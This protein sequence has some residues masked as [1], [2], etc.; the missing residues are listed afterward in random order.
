MG[1]AISV[2]THRGIWDVH[3]SQCSWLSLTESVMI[4][5][6]VVPQFK[7]FSEDTPLHDL[8]VS[9]VKILW[10]H[11]GQGWKLRLSSLSS[12]ASNKSLCLRKSALHRSNRNWSIPLPSHDVGI[13]VNSG[14]L[15]VMTSRFWD[16]VSWE[17][18]AFHK[19]SYPII[20]RYK[21]LEHFPKALGDFSEIERFVYN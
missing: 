4:G 8:F 2:L 12:K 5:N 3:C 14:G 18:W 21:R 1:N 19:I 11:S 16:G 20:Y 15:G 6:V 7:W 10:C 13:I 17:A 9:D